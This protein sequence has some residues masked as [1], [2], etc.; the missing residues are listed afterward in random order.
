MFE[1][2]YYLGSMSEE[3]NYV[4]L[5]NGTDRLIL[6]AMDEDSTVSYDDTL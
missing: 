5:T 1:I 6:K 3:D 2:S 4:L